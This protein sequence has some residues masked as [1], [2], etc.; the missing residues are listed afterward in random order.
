MFIAQIASRKYSQLDMRRTQ[1]SRSWLAALLLLLGIV[2]VVI[3]MP[4]SAA[5]V[6]DHYQP[7]FML[8][9]ERALQRG[10]AQQALDVLAAAQQSI[11]GSRYEAKAMGIR[12][13]AY[14][15]MGQAEAAREQCQG[16]IERSSSLHSW[17]YHN[18]LGVAEMQLGNLEAAEQ[19]FHRAAVLDGW[20]YG[21]RKNLEL[22]RELQQA[23]FIAA[24]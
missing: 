9:A 12:C 14:L 10:R 1:D 17:S 22:V 6:S 7:G 15:A 5:S 11:A 21:P 8:K 20:S 18:N 24:E 2:A 13:E 3:S 16:A 19:H 23:R 4:T